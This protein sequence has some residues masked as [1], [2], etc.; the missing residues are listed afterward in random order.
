MNGGVREQSADAVV[1]IQLRQ[2]RDDADPKVQLHKD[3]APRPHHPPQALRVRL[4]GT[5]ALRE[6]VCIVL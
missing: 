1:K 5:S 6:N 3:P 2:V 4:P